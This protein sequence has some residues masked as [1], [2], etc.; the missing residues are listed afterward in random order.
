MK[1]N[2]FWG[3]IILSLVFLACATAPSGETTRVETR[4]TKFEGRWVPYEI[5][6]PSP[7]TGHCIDF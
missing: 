4:E 1:K 6:V 3:A 2:Y 5:L 7:F